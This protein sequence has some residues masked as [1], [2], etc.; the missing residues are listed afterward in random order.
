MRTDRRLDKHA[1]RIRDVEYS[2]INNGCRMDEIERRHDIHKEHIKV[3]NDA[4][5]WYKANLPEEPDY[6]ECEQC[7]CLLKK[8]TAI[9]GESVIEVAPPID[10]TYIRIIEARFDPKES[11]REVYYCK[12]CQP[13]D[14][15]CEGCPAEFTSECDE[16]TKA[17]CGAEHE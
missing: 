9:R 17:S 5:E 14:D 3:H 6:V 2:V 10:N 16:D 7:G 8:Q 1:T 15:I 4:I 11:I 12:L 13:S